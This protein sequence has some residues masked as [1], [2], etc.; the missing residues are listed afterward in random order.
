MKIK[1]G[2]TIIMIMML[3][4]V[5]IF[6]QTGSIEGV[7]TDKGNKETL[8]GV[9]VTIEGTIIGAA[10]DFD[11]HFLIQNVKPGKYRLKVS[12]ISYNTEFIDNVTVTAGKTTTVPVAMSQNTVALEGVTVTGVRKTNTDVS[13]INVTRMS[14]NVSIA[15]SGQQ[16]LRSQDRDASEVIRRLPGTTIIDDRFIVVRGL[17][18]RYNAVWLNN[19][20]TPSSEAD[21]KAFSFDVIP[22]SM[23]ENMVIVKS[24]SPELPADFSGG[25]VKIATVNLPEKNSVFVS[26][27]TAFSEGTTLKNFK[28][29]EGGSTDWLGFDDGLR[30]LPKSMPSSLSVYESAAN[31]EIKNR[32]TEIGRQ[33]NKNW[34][35]LDGT[36]LPDQRF[37]V[38]FNKRFNV[39]S[40]SFGN[41]TALTYSNTNNHDEIT[42]NNYSI[43]DFKNDKSSYVDQFKDD[44]YSNSVKAGILHNWTWYPAAGQKIEF[45]N[46]FNQIGMTRSTIRN[47]REWYNDGRYIR[48]TELR[49]LNRS[50]YSGQVAGEHAFDEGATKINWV[51]GLSFSN[52]NEPDTK[53]YRYLRSEQ[54][55]SQYFLLFSDNADLSSESRMWFKLNE[56]VVSGALN[57]TREFDFSGFKPEF[58][59]GFYYEDKTREFA[60]RNFGYSKA[61]NSS[62]FDNTTL[63]VNNIFTDANINLT[64]GIKLTEIT[65]LSDSYNAS[66]KQYSA[67]IA[68]KI[69]ITESISLYTGLRAE[70][71]IQSLSSYRQGTTTPVNVK[72]DTLNF[73]PSANLAINL[74]ERNLIRAAYGLSINRPEFR[75]LA[76]FYFVD[77]DMNAGIYG[78]PD[79]KQAYI[80]NFDLRFEHYPT[81]NE[82]FN[83][84]VFYKSFTNPIEM[85]IMGNSPTQYSFE[86]V[87]SAYSYGIEADVRKSLGFISGY[88]NF[89][90]ILNAALI[91]SKV[92]FGNND[93][94]RDRSLQGQ[95]PYMVNAGIFYYNNDNGL[96]VTMLY[97]IIGKRIVA[98]GRP[99]PNSWEDIPNI[100]EMPRNVL[101]LAV[102]KKLG[103]KVEIKGGIKDI[104]NEKTQLIQSVNTAVDMGEITS[105]VQNGTKFFKKDQVTKSFQPGRY[106]SLGITYKF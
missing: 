60:A 99:S 103:S 59:A 26:Y 101:D 8:P 34:T 71:N 23:I 73:F 39:G 85:V 35:P 65:S 25:F 61:S 97:N 105:G 1:K 89:S 91:K 63:S 100:Y 38:G 21:A 86:N 31:P 92:Q 51:A 49:Y 67:Y 4:P 6:A 42:S 57:I 81:P 94:Q 98:V 45:R 64:D 66:N 17:A 43:Y 74:N 30:Q 33:L 13:M 93:L 12:Y 9:M 48:S 80:N 84:G 46:L 20:A 90:V 29:Y 55:T 2:L 37:A 44:Q 77:F 95:S 58:R 76:P 72:R 32:V 14:P 22:A 41:I 69:P 52:K 15:I 56:K 75:E 3:L 62:A 19:A 53:R 82:T 78:N 11:G 5:S 47:G 106:I 83:L 87:K 68:A 18:Q 96:M 88:E 36:A 102:S 79:I 27:N 54:D 40:Q 10:A 104:L 16:I 28:K 70:K 7:A 50:V 24:P